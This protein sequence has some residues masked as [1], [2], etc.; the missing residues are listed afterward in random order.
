MHIFLP[1]DSCIF[2]EA[3][4][5]MVTIVVYETGS[6]PSHFEI[7]VCNHCKA[8][9]KRRMTGSGVNSYL[10]FIRG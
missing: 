10:M 2:E 1:E 3:N 4:N 7:A 8:V 9:R 6:K 5:G